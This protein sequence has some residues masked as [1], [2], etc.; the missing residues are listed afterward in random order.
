VPKIRDGIWNFMKSRVV[1]VAQGAG[2]SGTWN[3][4]ARS[5]QPDPRAGGGPDVVDLSGE[6]FERRPDPSSPWNDKRDGDDTPQGRIL[7]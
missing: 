4:G 3:S 6:E 2:T 5:P 1:V 7:H